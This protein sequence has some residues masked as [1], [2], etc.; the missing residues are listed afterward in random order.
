MYVSL[1]IGQ[2]G[3]KKKNRK[4]RKTE[5]KPKNIVFRSRN[6]ADRFLNVFL[7]TNLSN[8]TMKICRSV[9]KQNTGV[10]YVFGHVGVFVSRLTVNNLRF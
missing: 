9:D 1:Q 2:N 5:V 3:I 6:T 10:N 8:C 4:K 7:S